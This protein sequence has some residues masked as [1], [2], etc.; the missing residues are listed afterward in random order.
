MGIFQDHTFFLTKLMC[1]CW[2]VL[3]LQGNTVWV[4]KARISLHAWTISL[5]YTHSISLA[6]SSAAQNSSLAIGH[7]RTLETVW[8]QKDQLMGP[9]A[10]L[11][12]YGHA[13]A[14]GSNHF[15]CWWKPVW[16]CCKSNILYS[17]I[18]DVNLQEDK[19]KG[20]KNEF[21]SLK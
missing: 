3:V 11:M 21:R 1:L 7:S 9:N 8:E 19:P 12:S 14:G 20:R 13:G 16:D 2:S 4:N 15:K 17:L 18:S 10:A 5:E 6:S